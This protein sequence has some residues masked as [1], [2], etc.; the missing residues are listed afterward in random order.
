MVAES[1]VFDY[2]DR[3]PAADLVE[4]HLR[5]SEKYRLPLRTGTYMY[6]LGKDDALIE[7]HL[8]NAA[9]VGLE[10]HN[11]M[12]YTHDA[13]GRPVSDAEIVAFY[14][15]AWEL[16]AK[17][18]VQPS[19]EVH[20]D[21][22][23]EDFRR[24][25]PVAGAVR[26][27]GVPFNFTLDYSHCVFKMDNPAEQEKCGIRAEV[28]SGALVLD[29]FEPGN[30][31]QRW[32]DEEIVVYLQFRPAAPNGPGNVWAKGPDGKP[33]RGIQY[34]FVK[35]RPGEWHSP[36]QAW[37]L[38]PAKEA[39]RTVLRH[40][41]KSA[42]SPLRFVTTEMITLPDYGEGARYSLFDH[43]VAC[44]RWLRDTWKTIKEAN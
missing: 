15:R 37:K 24:V 30:L 13:A 22:W 42:R 23:S 38:E 6:R 8:R 31:C 36:W 25:L 1:G 21:V 5:C 26:A 39:A 43:N 20:V 9:R 44:A 2:L 32:L 33:G 28:E 7:N 34:P 27:R 40:H 11:V 35:P 17:H 10:V 29:P 14:L 16:G 3:L 12:V 18:G 4:E 19:F 41:R